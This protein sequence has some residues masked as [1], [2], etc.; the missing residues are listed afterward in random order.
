M[1]LL[2]KGPCSNV[3]GSEYRIEPLDDELCAVTLT[4]CWRREERAREISD[5]YDIMCACREFEDIDAISLLKDI[6]PKV[7]P[8]FAIATPIPFYLPYGLLWFTDI[9]FRAIWLSLEGRAVSEFTLSY[10]VYFMSVIA[11]AMCRD[12]PKIRD[13]CAEYIMFVRELP[14]L[15]SSEDHYAMLNSLGE[16]FANGILI[17]NPRYDPR[18]CERLLRRLKFEE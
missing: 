10:G 13:R 2:F 3:W 4:R 8:S 5:A 1:V 7:N 6:V 18:H 9:P 11:E 16:R 14:H 17:I 12:N 15:I